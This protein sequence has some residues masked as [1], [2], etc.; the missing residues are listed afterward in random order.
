MGHVHGS[1]GMRYEVADEQ[2]IVRVTH[3]HWS[4][5][6]YTPAYTVEV[7]A[8]G[9]DLH[10]L[11]SYLVSAIRVRILRDMPVVGA[12]VCDQVARQLRHRVELVSEMRHPTLASPIDNHEAS[13][14]GVYQ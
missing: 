14:H 12:D 6:V 5:R 4:G 11:A 13:L 8:A 2:C 7:R 9:Q 10:R 3:G 1:H